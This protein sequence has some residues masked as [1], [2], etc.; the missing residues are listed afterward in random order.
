MDWRLLQHRRSCNLLSRG[1]METG[2][3]TPTTPTVS[4]IIA[5]V[6][7]QEAVKLLHGMDVIAGRG[8]VFNG[9][10]AEAYQIQFQRKENCYSHDAL[11]E[12]V[13]L[14][15]RADSI[16][17]RELLAEARARL[18]PATELELARDV[19]EKLVCPKCETTEQ[20][21]ASLGRVPAENAW[22]PSCADVR[23]EVVTF[24]K[25][26]G[27]ESFLDRTLAE[28]GVPAFDIVIA[29][30]PVDGRS[31]GLELSW[32]AVNVLGPLNDAAG[33]VSTRATNLGRDDLA[34]PRAGAEELEWT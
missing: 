33:H 1:E 3:K 8:W 13:L 17:V 22:C 6:Q 18:G 34:L 28:I 30:S 19:L 23:R 4:S 32:D 16:T 14:P 27:D 20:L 24:F 2:G 26:R 5:G 12:V 15:A 9:L 11:D 21:F 7:T 25:I 10:S 31:F 29:R